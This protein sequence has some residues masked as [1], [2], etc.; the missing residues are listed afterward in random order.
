MGFFAHAFDIR[1]IDTTLKI[2]MFLSFG[3]LWLV[4]WQIRMVDE[5]V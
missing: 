1:C 4:F 5:D 2:L 3:E